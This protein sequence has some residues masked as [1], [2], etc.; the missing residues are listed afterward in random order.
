MLSSIKSFGHLT[1]K[2]DKKL[3]LK[4]WM[5]GLSSLDSMKIQ[6]AAIRLHLEESLA[7]NLRE[8]DDLIAV[9]N[10]T[11][12]QPFLDI[13]THPNFDSSIN[14]RYGR[15]RQIYDEIH[16]LGLY[17]QISQNFKDSFVKIDT[18]QDQQNCDEICDELCQYWNEL[19]IDS[20]DGWNNQVLH[21]NLSLKTQQLKYKSMKNFLIDCRKNSNFLRR[22]S[23]P[24]A[25]SI[26]LD[27]MQ[28]KKI[29]PLQIESLKERG[30]LCLSLDN[31]LPKFSDDVYFREKFE[32]NFGFTTCSYS[33]AGR[34]KYQYDSASYEELGIRGF[35]QVLSNLFRANETAIQVLAVLYLEDGPLQ[36]LK[37][38]HLRINSFISASQEGYLIKNTDNFYTKLVNKF[39]TEA[40]LVDEDTKKAETYK[41]P[42]HQ[43]RIRNLM[44]LKD[45]NE[46]KFNNKEQFIYGPFWTGDLWNF[47]FLQ[48]LIDNIG[49]EDPEF[50]QNSEIGN[51]MTKLVNELD[52]QNMPFGYNKILLNKYLTDSSYQKNP[53]NK[54][55][56]SQKKVFGDSIATQ[57]EL[58][59]SNNEKI[60]I[61]NCSLNPNYI[62][63]NTTRDFFV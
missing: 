7:D 54:A 10:Q 53:Q 5:C 3:G 2:T 26:K 11:H 25:I 41:L 1:K 45:F 57:E 20:E 13:K 47:E 43:F 50:L 34:N 17:D 44:N 37:K 56:K 49:K 9:I 63:F 62:K 60:S 39:E 33:T 40:N 51:H 46:K 16:N 58:P 22:L 14:K 8:D 31:F 61:K 30:I 42:A 21:S 32:E 4:R 18:E 12:I 38:D 59:V 55:H 29:L 23:K 28:D 35:I 52:V 19:E 27:L 15:L 36:I 48:K 24:K 6:S